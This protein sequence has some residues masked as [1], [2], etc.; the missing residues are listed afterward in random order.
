A[1][2]SLEVLPPF[3]P[4]EDMVAG[5]AP[6]PIFVGE[7]GS[8]LD[9]SSKA[10]APAAQA[11]DRLMAN[12]AATEWDQEETALLLR[13]CK[14]N[15]T[16]V[17]GAICAAAS[18]HLPASDANIIRMHCPVDLG[19]IMRVEIT[20]CGVFIAPGIVEIVTARRK[21]LWDDA[22]DIVDRL[23]TAR[24]PTAVAGMLEWISG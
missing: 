17:H 5:V 19:R 22:R 12:V 20:G 1:G 15:G 14:A 10:R 2:E 21:S 8:R 7:G 11:P 4:V 24:S 13:S 6:G 3:P 16:T 18:R 9:T 23:R